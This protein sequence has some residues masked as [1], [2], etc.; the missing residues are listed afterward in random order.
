MKILTVLTDGSLTFPTKSLVGSIGD[1]SRV[2]AAGTEVPEEFCFAAGLTVLGAICGTA[3]K[4]EIGC[5]VEP[6]LYTVLLGESYGV[7]K[8]TAM[9][10]VID[11]L[12]DLC[13]GHPI[14]TTLHVVQG[15]GSAEWMAR[16]L[17][18]HPKM[19]LA[20]DELKTLVDKFRVQGS[21]LLA[22]VTSL[23]EGTRW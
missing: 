16:E 5:D 8:S 21:A 12:R 15:V 4:L 9:R 11:S 22:M 13:S 23:F 10:K 1:L 2:L 20:Y 17:K 3:L 7:K 19:L 18:D 14:K 6:G